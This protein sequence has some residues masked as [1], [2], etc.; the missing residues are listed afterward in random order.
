LNSCERVFAEGLFSG[1]RLEGVDLA[2]GLR[3][4]SRVFGEVEEDLA[5]GEVGDLV[6]VAGRFDPF[7]AAVVVE[8][9]CD[10]VGGAVFADLVFEFAPLASIECSILCDGIAGQE[11]VFGIGEIGDWGEVAAVEARVGEG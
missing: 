9:A 3:A 7:V 8:G 10:D 5:V 4:G 6:D 11:G 2:C 1:R